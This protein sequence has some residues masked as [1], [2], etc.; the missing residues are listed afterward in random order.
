MY[1]QEDAPQDIRYIDLQKKILRCN[2]TALC[3]YIKIAKEIWNKTLLFTYMY[4][5][6]VHM[7]H[8]L[9]LQGST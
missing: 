8:N 6:Y 1:A 7:Q 2:K 3:S 9:S 4:I 5:I